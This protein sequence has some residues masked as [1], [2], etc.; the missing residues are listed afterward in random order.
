MLHYAHRSI[1]RMMPCNC[2]WPVICFF[3]HGTKSPWGLRQLNFHFEIFLPNPCVG[4]SG[5]S[6]NRLK[7]LPWRYSKN[8]GDYTSKQHSNDLF[9][10]LH[11]ENTCN[12]GWL[13]SNVFSRKLGWQLGQWRAAEMEEAWP[14]FDKAGVCLSEPPF[15]FWK[16]VWYLSWPCIH[17]SRE[18][19]PFCF[20]RVVR[21][22]DWGAALL[23]AVIMLGS[24]LGSLFS[25]WS[26][27]S[28]LTSDLCKLRCQIFSC[29][30]FFIE[31]RTKSLWA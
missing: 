21:V 26:I 31:C 3:C 22:Q 11:T 15:H 13:I 7:A 8:Q 27:H 18:K 16:Q 24:R 23:R 5:C 20:S 19:Q 10:D 1:H 4:C 29:G 17:L 14:K 9:M 2:A 30:L 6:G 12:E 28:E 25:R